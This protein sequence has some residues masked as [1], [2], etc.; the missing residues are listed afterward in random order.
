M[1]TG[2]SQIVI[3]SGA[4]GTGD[5]EIV[6][7]N[8]YITAIK[9]HVT[10]ISAY[11]DIRIKKNIKNSTLGLNFINKLRPVRYNKVNPADY[12]EEL[13]EKRFPKNR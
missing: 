7:G 1:V 2:S 9:S 5:H 10:S 4:I 3:G 12:P 8:G 13:L 11:S 6:L